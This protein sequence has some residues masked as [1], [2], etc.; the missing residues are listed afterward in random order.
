MKILS[1]RKIY[2]DPE[3]YGLVRVETDEGAYI[4]VISFDPDEM[5]TDAEFAELVAKNEISL[6]LDHVWFT[7]KD[8]SEKEV[9]VVR[10]LYDTLWNSDNGCTT[11]ISIED[12]CEDCNITRDKL[13][14]IVTSF[15]NI[16][17]NFLQEGVLE[18]ETCFDEDED[19]EDIGIFYCFFEYFDIYSFDTFNQR[20]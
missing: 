1:F 6:T 4:R 8:C 14:E 5:P 12:V 13:K 18:W 11:F 7:A 16:K 19:D 9:K 10:Y 17:V 3:G 15:G 20:W 2:N